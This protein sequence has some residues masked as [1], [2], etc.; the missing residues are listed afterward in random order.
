VAFQLRDW[1]AKRVAGQSGNFGAVE[2]D[3]RSIRQLQFNL[4]RAKSGSEEMEILDDE[5][6]DLE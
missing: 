2:F 1:D 4:S 3:P 5:V 6:W